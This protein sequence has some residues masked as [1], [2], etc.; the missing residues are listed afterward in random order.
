MSLLN[1]KIFDKD[2]KIEQLNLKINIL[3]EEN[4]KMKESYEKLFSKLT[5]IQENNIL[6]PKDGKRVKVEDT[7]SLATG[8]EDYMISLQ[9]EVRNLHYL[10][11]Q[12]D[13]TIEKLKQAYLTYGQNK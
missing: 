4:S 8:D 3:T 5:M 11:K 13:I 7:K 9:E 12:K 2:E 6:I 10:V 1:E